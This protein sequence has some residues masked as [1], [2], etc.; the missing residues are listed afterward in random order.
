M[1]CSATTPGDPNHARA[2]GVRLTYLFE[3]EYSCYEIEGGTVL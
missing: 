3:E 2:Q 1:R